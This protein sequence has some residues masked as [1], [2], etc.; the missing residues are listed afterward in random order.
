MISSVH[1]SSSE[2]YQL[3]TIA[4]FPVSQSYKIYVNKN[5]PQS[6]LVKT[7]FLEDPLGAVAFFAKNAT[8][9]SRLV[10]LADLEGATSLNDAVDILFYARPYDVQKEIS[11]KHI[12]KIL[13]L[14]SY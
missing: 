11:R 14:S 5:S 12:K 8:G 3:L 1:G 9:E 6:I 7:E 4:I 10:Y 13:H 2:R